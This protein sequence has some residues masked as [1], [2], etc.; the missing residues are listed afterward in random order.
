MEVLGRRP[1]HAEL[2]SWLLMVLV[3]MHAYWF[4]LILLALHRFLVVGEKGDPREDD[5]M[6]GPKAD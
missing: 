1:W 5:D 4:W 3:I 2:L 6:E